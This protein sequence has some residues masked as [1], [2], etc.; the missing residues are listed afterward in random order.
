MCLA[1]R[2]PKIKNLK[3]KLYPGSTSSILLCSRFMFL[4]V[5][6]KSDH[7]VCEAIN[8]TLAL[9]RWAVQEP[10][11]VLH[12]WLAQQAHLERSLHRDL[13]KP[14][15]LW[16]LC[17]HTQVLRAR[18]VKYSPCCPDKITRT[19]Q[20]LV[21]LLA[22]SSFETSNAVPWG[23]WATAIYIL[24]GLQFARRFL[25]YAFLMII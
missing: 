25:N 9:P 13:P 17:F 15:A 20:A 24:E 8:K 1:L 4:P 3:T 14:A 22:F 12:P 16:L 18:G 23:P 2:K 7:L 10:A 21:T 6:S 5:T 11:A 19:L